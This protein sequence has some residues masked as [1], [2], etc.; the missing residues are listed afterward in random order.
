[1]NQANKIITRYATAHQETSVVLA[2]FFVQ[3]SGHCKGKYMYDSTMVNC[4]SKAAHHVLSF[5]DNYLRA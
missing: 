4:L 1:M 5:K 2:N 3:Q